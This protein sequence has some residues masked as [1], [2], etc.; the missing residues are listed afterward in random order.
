[1]TEQHAVSELVRY[2]AAA[3]RIAVLSGAGMSTESGIPDFRS[4]TG[5]YATVV[6]ESIFDIDAFRTNPGEFYAFARVFFADMLKAE[7][8]R[9]HTALARLE[10]ELGK[11]VRIATQNIDTLHQRAGSTRV[12]PVHGTT[13]TCSCLRCGH[14]TDTAEIWAD[15]TAGNIPRHAGCGGLYK[16]DIVFF[17]EWLPEAVVAAAQ[18]AMAKADLVLAVGTSLAVQPAA[19]LPHGRRSGTPYVIINRTPT[20]QDSFADLVIRESIGDV[21]NAA[22]GR[23]LSE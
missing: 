7:P 6:S 13:E 2:L 19:S 17:G 23:L 22:V 12:Y 1:M 10:H 9:G 15:I 3:K 5:I 11:D 21:L 4:S 16:P 14:R 20:S 8:N 18:D